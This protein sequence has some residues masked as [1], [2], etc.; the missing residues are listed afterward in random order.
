MKTIKKTNE[1]FNWRRMQ[2]INL[3]ITNLFPFN[4]PNLKQFMSQNVIMIDNLVTTL[5]GL[6]EE[7]KDIKIE[8][9]DINLNRI[10]G[11]EPK[12]DFEDWLCGANN[13]YAI[14]SYHNDY[15]KM[16][17][18]QELEQYYSRVERVARCKE[19]QD[20]IAK[21]VVSIEK[22]EKISPELAKLNKE[23]LA[24]MERELESIDKTLEVKTE[25]EI[26]TLLHSV[27]L[28]VLQSIKDNVNNNLEYFKEM[29]RNR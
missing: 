12:T 17:K 28:S 7:L 9:A 27:A 24:K 13:G 16:L 8:R 26:I 29:Q 10:Y 3:F 22:L 18:G 21:N 15:L 25:E 11:N 19:L 23:N 4:N 14:G 6:K 1:K 2:Q 5:E 20:E